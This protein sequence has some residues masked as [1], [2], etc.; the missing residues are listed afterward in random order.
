MYETLRDQVYFSVYLC[1][2]W[3][4]ACIQVYLFLFKLNFLSDY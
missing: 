4:N 1:P 3:N 2:V